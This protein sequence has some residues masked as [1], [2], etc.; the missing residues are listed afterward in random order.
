MNP[1]QDREVAYWMV[2]RKWAWLLA[3]GGTLLGTGLI[4]PAVR[5]PVDLLVELPFTYLILFLTIRFAARYVGGVGRPRPTPA[6]G[7]GPSQP[8]QS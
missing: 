8:S 6:K 5:R 4:A 7:P 3:M 1:G 2:V